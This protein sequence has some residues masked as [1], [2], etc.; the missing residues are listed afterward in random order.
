MNL[1]LTCF[2]GGTASSYDDRTTQVEMFGVWCDA[3]DV[4]NWAGPLP[5]SRH[6]KMCFDGVGVTNGFSGMVFA[7]GLS[8]QV[9]RVVSV[10]SEIMS[11][12]DARLC[13]NA[14]GLSRGGCGC[15]LLAKALQA[16][17]GDSVDANLLLFDPVPGNSIT[18]AT[19]DVLGLTLASQ[20]AD[21]R[22]V[23]CVK[24]VLAL[25]PHEPLPT[26]YLHAPVVP[27]FADSTLVDEDVM[28]GCHQGPIY[29]FAVRDLASRMC[30]GVFF[31][32]TERS[33]Y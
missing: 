12:K 16:A 6:L 23:T 14:I 3:V 27:K 26:H 1:T 5:T 32:S 22:H 4:T 24:R 28:L 33:I 17:F 18:S 29:S 15:L 11:A 10:C 30:F 2:F 20:C 21:L 31:S 25:F 9:A 8:A 7:A 19:M 13:V